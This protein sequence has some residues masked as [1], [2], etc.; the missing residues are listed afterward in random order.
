MAEQAPLHFVFYFG[1]PADKVWGGFVLPE[2][3]R[4]IFGGA[5]LEVDLR[6]GGRMN[7]VGT[8]PDGARITYVRGE[9]LEA[10]PPRRLQYT[11][12]LGSSSAISRVTV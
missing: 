2:P 10:D 6:P 9:V 4:I 8:G 5:D 1:A 3:N 12:A 11:F 7:W